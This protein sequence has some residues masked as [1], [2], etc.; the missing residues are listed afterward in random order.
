MTVYIANAVGVLAAV[1]YVLSYQQKRRKWI[2]LLGAISRMLFVAQYVLLGAYEGAV[3]DVIGALAGLLAGRK[4]APFIKKNLPW[5][6]ATIHLAI[7]GVGIWLYVDVFSI[8]VIAATT[9][10]VGALWFSKE[11]TIR[12][13]SLAGSPCWLVYNV[14]SKAYPS[15]VSDSFTIVSIIVAMFRYD[16]HFKGKKQ[17]AKDAVQPES[18]GEQ[19]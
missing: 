14:A 4:E 18:K 5:I 13:L 8:F 15:A 17:R 16:F 1:I 2:V 12:R 3:L 19:E 11:K 10:H 7:L 6:I 9:L